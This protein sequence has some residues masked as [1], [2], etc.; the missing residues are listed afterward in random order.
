MR[1]QSWKKHGAIAATIALVGTLLSQSPVVAQSTDPVLCNGLTPTIVG[2]DGDDVLQGTFQDDVIVGLGGND[3]IRGASGSDMICGGDGDDTIFGESQPDTIFG[4]PGNDTITGADGADVIDGGPGNDNIVGDSG[5]DTIQGGDDDDDINGGSGDDTLDGGNGVDIVD[6]LWNNDTCDDAETAI[7]CETI[8]TNGEDDTGGNGDGGDPVDPGPDPDAPP[9]CNGLLPTIVGTDGDDVIDGTFQDDVIVGLG[10]NDTIRGGSGSDTICGGDGD[11]FIDGQS[12]DDTIFGEAGNDEIRGA[13]G[14]DTLD[15]GAG[16]DVILGQSQPDTIFGGPGNDTITGAD[17]ADVIDGGPG[18]DIITGDSQN[19]IIQG[20]DGDDDI[21]GGSG[22]DTLDGGNGVDIVDGLWNNDTCDDAETAINCETETNNGEDDPVDP[23]TDTDGD[24]IPDSEDP[25]IDGDGTLNEDDAFPLDANEDTD[26][27]GDGVGDNTDEDIDGDGTPNIDDAFPIDANEDTDTDGDGVG[28]NADDDD[29][30]D[31]IPDV[32]DPNPLEPGG[33]DIDS[34]GDG[35]IDE[36]DDFPNDPNETSDTDGDGIG[37][38]SDPDADNDGVPNEQDAFPFDDSESV[39]SDGG[40]LGDNADPDD[41]DDGV[42]D[43]ED[44]FPNDPTESADTDGDG[45]GNNA[46]PDDDG[47]GV[48]DEDDAFPTDADE[49]LD[50]DFDGIGDSV[51]DDHDNDGVLNIDDQFPDDPFESTDSDGDGIGDFRDSDR[52]DDGVHDLIDAFPDAASLS[53]DIDRDGIDD[54]SDDDID[55]DGVVNSEDDFPLYASES[56]DADE[57]GFGDNFD[58]VR[59]RDLDGVPDESDA[60]LDG[61]GVPNDEDLF[62][63]DLSESLDSDGDGVGDNADDDDD[64]DGVP[65]VEDLLPLDP[66]AGADADADGTPD[67]FDV[68]P[69]SAAE[70]RFLVEAADEAG[71]AVITSDVL[72]LSEEV[73]IVEVPIDESDPIASVAASSAVDFTVTAPLEGFETARITIPIDP[74]LATADDSVEVW[75]FNEEIGLWVLDGTN[76]VV[77]QAASTVSVTVDHFSVFIALERNARPYAYSQNPNQ[78]IDLGTDLLFLLDVSGST[79]FDYIV[80][81]ELVEASDSQDGSTERETVARAVLDRLGSQDRVGVLSMAELTEA[82][83]LAFI[84]DD[85]TAG[86]PLVIEAVQNAVAETRSGTD[87]LEGVRFASEQLTGDEASGRANVVVLLTDGGSDS[88]SEIEVENVVDSSVTIHVVELGDISRNGSLDNVAT[89]TGGAFAGTGDSDGLLNV[90]DRVSESVDG[91]GNDGDQDGLSNCEE[92]RGLLTDVLWSTTSNPDPRDDL[93]LSFTDPSK[94]DS[95]GDLLWDSEELRRVRL[96]TDNLRD[97]YEAVLLAGFDSVFVRV[98]DP[99]NVNIP[100]RE[101]GVQTTASYVPQRSPEEAVAGK[102]ARLDIVV[103]RLREFA[104][105]T[106]AVLPLAIEQTA[107][108]FGLGANSHERFVIE[109]LD[110]MAEYPPLSASA[111]EFIANNDAL[112]QRPAVLFND[113]ARILSSTQAGNDGNLT[114]T[115]LYW[116]GVLEAKQAEIDSLPNGA[117]LDQLVADRDYAARQLASRLLVATEANDQ[118]RLSLYADLII[119]LRTRNQI[120]DERGLPVNLSYRSSY[121]LVRL[122]ANSPFAFADRVSDL[123]DLF[124]FD[125][126]TN[127]PT[128]TADQLGLTGDE[129]VVRYQQLLLQLLAGRSQ[130]IEDWI[131]GNSPDNP[132]FTA[133]ELAG[134]E[135]LSEN[136]SLIGDVNRPVV[137]DE[138]SCTQYSTTW[139]S[140]GGPCESATVY[141][142]SVLWSE[143]R[144]APGADVALNYPLLQGM[145][146]DMARSDVWS[147]DVWVDEFTPRD[148]GGPIDVDSANYYMNAYAS[149]P[150]YPIVPVGAEGATWSQPEAYPGLVTTQDLQRVLLTAELYDLFSD[151]PVREQIDTAWSAWWNENRMADRTFSEADLNSFLAQA[152]ATGEIPDVVLDRLDQALELGVYDERFSTEDATNALIALSIALS[153]VGGVYGVTSTVGARLILAGAVADGGSVV[154]TASNGQFGAFDALGVV[155][156]MF[157]VAA[158]SGPARAFAEAG[159]SAASRDLFEAVATARRAADGTA[160]SLYRGL[161]GVS[162][163]DG[164]LLVLTRAAEGA[165]V[166]LSDEAATVIMEARVRDGIVAEARSNG[167]TPEQAA[168]FADAGL[169]SGR[170][171]LDPDRFLAA[172]AFRASGGENADFALVRFGDEVVGHPQAEELIAIAA[173]CRS[174]PAASALCNTFVTADEAGSLLTLESTLDDLELKGWVDSWASTGSSFRQTSLSTF[175]RWTSDNAA[176]ARE[177]LVSS[178]GW[179]RGASTIDGHL[180]VLLDAAGSNVV[181]RRVSGDTT[182]LLSLRSNLNEI[183]GKVDILDDIS[184][185]RLDARIADAVLQ[186]PDASEVLGQLRVRPSDLSESAGESAPLLTSNAPLVDRTVDV[187]GG[188]RRIRFP[189]SNVEVVELPNGGLRVTFANGDTVD[190]VGGFPEFIRG[191]TANG[192]QALEADIVLDQGDIIGFD[193]F[194]AANQKLASQLDQYP[195]MAPDLRAWISNNSNSSSSPPNY[196]WHH[197]QETG[198]MQLVEFTLHNQA[199]HTGGNSFWGQKVLQDFLARVS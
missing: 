31:G 5:N 100:V 70:S 97:D 61:D 77:D 102:Q 157:D 196:T 188:D 105:A 80:G 55:G 10:G 81:G 180:E 164:E 8:T 148:F 68:D 92:I 79:E 112:I 76:L 65:D 11:D 186:R 35:V 54:A 6:G 155:F 44:A 110:N 37:D 165:G 145:W 133:T 64:N 195:E 47:D 111:A 82:A 171:T 66:N 18:D 22:D 199:S 168:D 67:A 56:T 74:S 161:D 159:G 104:V 167:M 163:V 1:D 162:T 179:V 85:Q 113:Q 52:D 19:D 101:D 130:Q 39:D 7:N 125:G 95:D 2:T 50:G 170:N 173:S 89:A 169:S 120:F 176:A 21:N 178:P 62:P 152:R 46:D 117:V 49:S 4:G 25:D 127:T 132:F 40:G 128:V 190:Y 172:E 32:D 42:F 184:S 17:G 182:S 91:G 96:D 20:G 90:L 71:S 177:I 30:D 59:D 189:R 36:L 63:T 119:S 116:I 27:D 144:Q 183:L 141:G 181:L 122:Y 136:F 118:F 146:D 83:D 69:S 78:C 156:L 131:S 13:D 134:V 198:R 57:N 126:V 192:R 15:G 140:A 34:D 41:D 185:V 142:Y 72:I 86:Y 175:A 103:S 150:G 137:S 51:D 94:A 154:L 160:G 28:N 194:R 109:L 16:N 114:D 166:Q 14:A 139:N 87:I 135:W 197:H 48:L 60:D 12:Q 29:D 108:E 3:T 88:I 53:A 129:G 107:I 158:L 191:T 187:L 99:N 58:A 38:N 98:G 143:A 84:D 33:V 75:W 123:N 26:T 73:E 149:I 45:I 174:N 151:S 121:E 9:L 24:G 93:P 153:G 193:D 106:D 138:V 147:G 115:E 124:R 43:D 23:G